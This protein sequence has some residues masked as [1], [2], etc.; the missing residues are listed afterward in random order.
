[1]KPFFGLLCLPVL[2]VLMAG[3]GSGDPDTG[4][5]GTP[6]EP[7]AAAINAAPTEGDAPLTVDVDASASTGDIVA[8]EWD[9]D[10]DG[11]TFGV[12]DTGVIATFNYP[13]FGQYVV[14]LRVT[15]SDS[16]TDVTT[17]TVSVNTPGNSMPIAALTATPASGAAPLAVLLDAA[18]S[19]DS[20]GVVTTYLWDFDY[21]GF[22]V[23]DARTSAPTSS[24]THTYYFPGTFTAAVKVLDDAGGWDT[25]TADVTV[26]DTVITFADANLE[27][28]VREAI[29]KETG[30]IYASD[31]ATLTTLDASG[32]SIADLGGLARCHNIANLNLGNN[33]ISS[34]DELATMTRLEWVYLYDNGISDITA[35]QNLS[36]L[37]GLS[38]RGNSVADLS[39]LGSCSKLA[40]LN[41]ADNSLNDL[42][43]LQTCVSLAWLDFS[44]NNITDISPIVDLPDIRRIAAAGNSVTDISGMAGKLPALEEFSLANNG[45]SD[46]SALAGHAS[47]GILDL[48]LNSITDITPIQN[49][50]LLTDLNLGGN[51][52]A[53]TAPLLNLTGMR[54]LNLIGCGISSIADVSGMTELRGLY[55]TL[56]NVTDLS[57]LTGA[58]H[59]R[60]L[61]ANNN[62][63]LSDLSDLSGLLELGWLVLSNN[64]ISDITALVTNSTS[65]GLGMGDIIDLQGNPLSAQAT[66]VD[67][68][69][70]EA[71]DVQVLH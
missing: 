68:P 24:V 13:V 17:V 59:L 48:S 39:P 65:G 60:V 54:Y 71:N 69:L 35:L 55:I 34:V 11:A 36:R 52:L 53:S 2:V 58:A 56:N 43:A 45:I 44:G 5:P 64:N 42:T 33:S 47:L 6:P 51:V 26:T 29:D 15:D 8:Y 49:L 70:L 41:I 31:V 23:E 22:F 3:C 20:D 14:A 30:D 1:M 21:D 61:F 38:L 37:K 7:L 19:S 67:I 66:G 62:P 57:P 25:D 63:S 18:A 46:I 50:T 28:A 27:A 40:D 9:S 32:C 4:G 10:Y 12:D 16:V